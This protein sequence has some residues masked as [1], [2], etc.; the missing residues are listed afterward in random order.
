MPSA[1]SIRPIVI[2]HTRDTSLIEG[3][4]LA[5][6]ESVP[7]CTPGRREARRNAPHKPVVRGVR[8]SAGRGAPRRPAAGFEW[9]RG[10]TRAVVSTAA[11]R[12]RERGLSPWQ[13]VIRTEDA[14]HAERIGSIRAYPIPAYQTA[15]L[16][17]D[18]N[19]QNA[20]CSAAYLP[21]GPAVV[22]DLARLDRSMVSDR[23]E[24]R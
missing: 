8:V 11:V 1:P 17:S 16:A 5:M 13:S 7:L 9:D 10:G 19:R 4:A 12:D 23:V 18:V 22:L 2:S 15:L 6:P 20:S 3:Y 14:Q 24:H 21:A